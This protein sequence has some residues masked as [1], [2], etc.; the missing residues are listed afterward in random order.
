[1]KENTWDI[2]NKELKYFGIKLIGN[3]KCQFYNKEEALRTFPVK[4]TIQNIEFNISNNIKLFSETWDNICN[5]LT[6]KENN[7]QCYD[8]NLKKLFKFSLKEL[9]KLLLAFEDM[10]NSNISKTIDNALNQDI[11]SFSHQQIDTLS[12]YKISI[13]WIHRLIH[14]HKYLVSLLK[15]S[16]CG[17]D[18]ISKKEIKLARGVSGPWANLDLPMLERVYSFESEDLRGLKGRSRD[19]KYQRRYQKGLDNYNSEGVGEGHYW[20]ELRNEPFLWSNRKTD[21]P[22]PGRNILMN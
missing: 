6:N 16:C 10:D 21:S 9:Q 20:R 5:V 18:V 7:H 15:L 3:N 19:K 14:L 11:N 12:N 13:D 17:K 8:Q 1:M 4:K 2:L 22:Y